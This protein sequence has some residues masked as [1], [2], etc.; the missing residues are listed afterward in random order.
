MRPYGTKMATANSR[1]VL[2]TTPA[3][4]LRAEDFRLEDG[5]TPAPGPGQ[6]LCRNVILS[7]DP[8]ARAWI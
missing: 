8:A 6:V 2:T 7:I 3:E 5:E 1:I 4:Q